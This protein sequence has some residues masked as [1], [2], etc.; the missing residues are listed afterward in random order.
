[1]NCPNKLPQQCRNIQSFCLKI[2]KVMPGVQVCQEGGTQNS[3]GRCEYAEPC[4][5]ISSK[6]ECVRKG[7]MWCPS[8]RGIK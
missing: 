3:D 2:Q 8:S 7:Y 4:V 1:M 5:A 6:D